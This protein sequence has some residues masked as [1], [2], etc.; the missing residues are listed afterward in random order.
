MSSV[1]AAVSSVT[2]V[3]QRGPVSSAGTTGTDDDGVDPR[4]YTAATRAALAT[5]SKGHCY[6]PGCTEPTIKFIDGVPMTNYQIAHIRDANPGNRYD[7]AMSNEERR[8][9][10]NV[11]LLCL[12]HH[13]YVDKTRPDL[14]S[15]ST[16][17]GWKADRESSGIAE[18][19]GVDG[20]T[21]ERLEA[22]LRAVL[23]SVATPKPVN[24][25]WSSPEADF[26]NAA[27]EVLRVDDD[28]TI[29]RFLDRA[30]TDFRTSIAPGG[31][32]AE[33]TA[34]LDRLTELAAYAIR[35]GRPQHVTVVLNALEQMYSSILGDHGEL[36]ATL[37]APAH[38]LLM[39]IVDR[40]L[41]LGA[42][43]FETGTWELIPVVVVRR[44]PRMPSGYTNWFRHTMT[45]AAQA[46]R[47]FTYTD[48]DTGDVKRCTYLEHGIRSVAHLRC[49]NPD[50]PA[51]ETF[52]TRVVSFDALATCA[53]SH[54]AP[55]SKAFAYFPGHRAYD[56][57]RFE[58]ALA[59]LVEDPTIRAEVFP[60]GDAALAELLVDLE[61]T[62]PAS[63]VKFGGGWNYAHPTI[64]AF[65]AAERERRQRR[66]LLNAVEAHAAAH[67]IAIPV[68]SHGHS[69]TTVTYSD[70]SS[71]D[72]FSD[73]EQYKRQV[74]SGRVDPRMS[75]VGNPPRPIR[76]WSVDELT[77][78][79]DANGGT[80]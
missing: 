1:R 46:Q 73:L 49:L 51:L 37:M 72:T 71:R 5:L 24:L 50:A 77:A 2:A 62:T 54:F 68:G 16:L 53:V 10:K 55:G 78:W 75:F 58:P 47:D 56:G 20:L 60:G 28:I 63:L 17:E 30:T 4:G 7:A 80:G 76:D 70:G 33:A 36:R 38:E 29:R 14:F 25:S 31:S 59:G 45:S 42:V 52:R 41:G 8:A 6:Y 27:A 19:R 39:A 40:L 15:S 32:I 18:L 64:T 48:P 11:V 67:G 13:T 57:E 35:W 22:L 9:F 61:E 3:C 79:L 74:E 43:A 34:I 12:I 23:S 65:V 69:P 66:D 44:P 21:E 26:E